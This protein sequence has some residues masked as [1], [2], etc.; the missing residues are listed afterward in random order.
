MEFEIT[1]SAAL[2]STVSILFVWLHGHVSTYRVYFLDLAI[3]RDCEIDELGDKL[4][5][6]RLAHK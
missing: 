2:R 5:R 1:Y 4:L 6:R 3:V